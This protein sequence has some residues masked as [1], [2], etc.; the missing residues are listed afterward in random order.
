MSKETHFKEIVM[1]KKKY[2]Q[3]WKDYE[4]LT[5]QKHYNESYFDYN[6]ETR[7]GAKEKLLETLRKARFNI[8]GAALT[9]LKNSQPSILPSLFGSG[10]DAQYI[11]NLRN[12]DDRIYKLIDKLEADECVEEKDYK[13]T[14][15]IV[16]PRYFGLIIKEQLLFIIG[17][18][19]VI[20]LIWAF[21]Q[22]FH[23]H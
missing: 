1:T 14:Y 16:Y 12:A 15:S 6:E 4:E 3:L 21:F 19:T 8:Q 13:D 11:A 23:F 18:G 2:F 9:H 7:E 20:F 17:T 10:R 22:I 5:L